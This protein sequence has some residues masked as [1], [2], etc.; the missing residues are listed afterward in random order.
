V[1]WSIGGDGIDDGGVPQWDV[2]AD[3]DYRGDRSIRL[4]S[5]RPLRLRIGQS[6]ADPRVLATL[7]YIEEENEPSSFEA[8]AEHPLSLEG[9]WVLYVAIDNNQ[10]ITALHI[11]EGQVGPTGPGGF[12]PIP[13]HMER[14][15]RDIPAID[16][17]PP[18]KQTVQL[19][20][21]STDR[22]LLSYETPEGEK[23]LVTEDD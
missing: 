19:V 6:A 4:G 16:V 8:A 10:T 21:I 2:D 20:T 17:V 3:Y 15:N 5:A 11:S 7:Q 13:P 18:L 23:M 14:G 1:I 22:E 9:P 12:P